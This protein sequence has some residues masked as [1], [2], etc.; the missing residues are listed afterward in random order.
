MALQDVYNLGANAAFQQ[1]VQG[2]LL[3]YCINTVF[4]EVTNDQQTITITGGPSGGSFTLANGPLQSA[5]APAWND[6]AQVLA[7][8][9]N[10]VLA[11]GNSCVGTGGPLPNTGILITWMGGLAN[12]PQLVMGVTANNLTG[13]ASPNAAVA[14]TTTGVAAV[15]H[16]AR[17]TKASAILADPLTSAHQ[18]AA[19]LAT[20][21]AIQTDYVGGGG[22]QASVTDAHI[23]AA[24]VAQ[25]ND[26]T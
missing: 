18:I 26:F 22:N 1:R 9:L 15:N 3:T 21:A 19:A 14:H 16:A 4:A 12:S 25:F 5:V 6:T 10:A 2:S 24:I 11:S 13:G 17:A 20:D 7:S 8:R 23:N